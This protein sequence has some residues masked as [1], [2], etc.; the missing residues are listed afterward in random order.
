VQPYVVRQGDYLLKLASQFGFDA[1]TV[2]G[3]P[4]NQQLNTLRTDPNILFPGDVLQIPDPVAADP[5]SLTPGSTNNFV[6]TPPTATLQ[7][8]FIGADGSP[9]ASAAY[10]I[11]ELPAL[12]GQQTDGSGL[13]TI[14][15]PVSYET[16]TVVFTDS[17][18]AYQLQVGDMDPINSLSGIFKRLQNLGFIANDMDFD[19]TNFHVLRSALY[20]F[21]QSVSPSPASSPSIPP[22][23]P[24]SQPAP[25]SSGAA[26]SASSPST[27]PASGT[28]SS[29]PPSSGP[30]SSGPP[31]SGPPSSGPASGNALPDESGLSDDGTL[32]PQVADLLKQ[33]HGS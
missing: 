28:P 16:L 9:L 33:H 5:T 4:E 10:Q 8:Q 32:D 7:V 3:D 2:W 22:P 6:S 17:G 11:Q 21:Q 29:P 26:A 23:P 18:A 31:S 15:V 14:Q 19:P 12:T 13:A 24:S 27:P 25:P 1:D 20:L 30:P